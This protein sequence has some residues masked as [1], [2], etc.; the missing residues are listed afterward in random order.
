MEKFYKNLFLYISSDLIFY[1][2][3]V[4]ENCADQSKNLHLIEMK[5]MHILKNNN[6]QL[7]VTRE[8]KLNC[9]AE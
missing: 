4:S 3:V 5:G 9:R 8:V 1:E 6:I 2:N 7:L